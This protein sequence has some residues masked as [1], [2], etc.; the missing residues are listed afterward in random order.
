MPEFSNANL[1]EP[2]DSWLDLSLSY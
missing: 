2:S 1:L